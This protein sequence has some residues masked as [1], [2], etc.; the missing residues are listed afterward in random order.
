MPTPSRY[1]ACL[2]LALACT[3]ELTASVEP[4]SELVEAS[5]SGSRWS[6]EIRVD[7]ALEQMELGLCIE[8][9]RP[10]RLEASRGAIDFVAQARVRGGPALAREHGELVV[11]TLG[12]QG[13][14][15]LVI[16]LDAAARD[17]GRDSMRRGDTF[18]LAPKLWLWHPDRVPDEVEARARLD[19]PEGVALT[20]PW[21]HE[22]GGWRRLDRTGF[23]WNG[24]VALGRYE[25]IEFRAAECEFEV[26]VLEGARQASEAGIERWLR[27][28]AETSAELHG[29]FPR[30]RVSVVVI[31]ASRW[32]DDPV[33]FGMARRGGGGSAMLMLAADAQDDELPGEWV[34]VHELLHL[35]MPLVADPW[36]AEG[37][38]TY[39]TQILRARRGV[40]VDS[41]DHE[42]QILAALG[43]LARGFRRGRGGTRTLAHASES[44]RRFGGYTRVYWGGAA[45]AFDLDRRL[46]SASAGRHSLD[47]LMLLLAD[48]APLYRRWQ[49]ED[50]IALME[51]EVERWREAGELELEI[52][53]SKII[54]HRLEAKSLSPEVLALEGLAVEVERA[55]ELH[56]QAHPADEVMVRA[57]MFESNFSGPER[58]QKP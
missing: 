19:L 43:A 41:E 4:E 56:L 46:R 42:R 48:Y 57:G 25:P 34:A 36:M 8:G 9:P 15:D 28:A 27:V 58:A 35:G 1:L 6:Y 12:E 24:W 16:D 26:A 18:L 40:L 32:G 11:E 38:V 10:K 39:Y 3:P 22:A 45:V 55:G 54:E 49:A 21:P 52:S 33:V 31:P 14:L 2:A 37:F 44:M 51:A 30:D 50:L 47:D 29:R 5:G 13:C 7:E 20:V 23:A 17:E 53:L